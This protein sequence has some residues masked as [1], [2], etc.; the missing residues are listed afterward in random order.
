MSSVAATR[1]SASDAA[2]SRC[3]PRSAQATSPR[4]I[5]STRGGQS[6]PP[7]SNRVAAA[8]LVASGADAALLFAK[9]RR[10]LAPRLAPVRRDAARQLLAAGSDAAASYAVISRLFDIPGMLLLAAELAQAKRHAEQQHRRHSPYAKGNFDRE[11]RCQCR[12]G[13]VNSRHF[14]EVP[15]RRECSVE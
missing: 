1:A 8:P 2:M 4:A 14:A 5:A 9:R 10:W 6:A 11:G 7:I 12:Q 13:S 3:S 15:T